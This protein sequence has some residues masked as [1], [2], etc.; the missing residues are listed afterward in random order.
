DELLILDEPLSNLDASL[1]EQMRAE[2][3]Q[4]QRRTGT[5]TLYVT[6]DQ[7]EALELS[8]RICVMDKGRILEIGTP[9]ELYRNPRSVATARFLGDMEIWAC[10]V[11]S[12][13]Q[14]HAVV[15]TSFG[16]FHVEKNH[17]LAAARPV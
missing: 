6:H 11:E 13:A 8:D 3:R 2:L 14:G 16:R 1:R 10:E 4:V 7:H 5:T 17:D 12:R 9:R 15:R